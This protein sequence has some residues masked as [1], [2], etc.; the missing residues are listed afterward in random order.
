MS[1]WNITYHDTEKTVTEKASKA[2]ISKHVIDV[3][4][5]FNPNVNDVEF[6]FKEDSTFITTQYIW[7][8][9]HPPFRHIAII[10]KIAFV[11]GIA[12]N[13]VEVVKKNF[14]FLEE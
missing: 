9:K 8:E 10:I 1:I 3:Q 4:R 13:I 11:N 14:G 5:I 6:I 2:F 12:E 7:L